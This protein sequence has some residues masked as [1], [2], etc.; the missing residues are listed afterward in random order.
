MPWQVC[1]I[2]SKPVPI[3]PFLF[4]RFGF[5]DN[6]H[7]LCILFLEQLFVSSFAFYLDLVGFLWIAIISYHIIKNNIIKVGTRG[8]RGLEK[9][10]KT[11]VWSLKI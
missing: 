7:N 1:L 8:L 11:H 3:H 4:L 9:N 2:P 5:Y 6:R 10:I